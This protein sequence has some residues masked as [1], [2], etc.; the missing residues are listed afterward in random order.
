MRLSLLSE[1]ARDDAATTAIAREIVDKIKTSGPTKAKFSVSDPPFEVTLDPAVTTQD[2]KGWHDSTN[3]RT[4]ATVGTR[5]WFADPRT[6]PD[7]VVKLKDMIQHE[8]THRS[9]P[10]ALKQATWGDTLASLGRLFDQA[11]KVAAY[12]GHPSEVQAWI[13]GLRRQAKSGKV[14]FR[15]LFLNMCGTFYLG[16][17]KTTEKRRA[18]QMARDLSEKFATM[19]V[20]S[21]NYWPAR[22]VRPSAPNARIVERDPIGRRHG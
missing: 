19:P 14:P 4:G 13:S 2:S 11:G 21:A 17:L 18:I 12:Y 6:R 9:Q 8:L 5:D 22:T 16:F 3:G 20:S 15:K 1:F 7:F 10:A